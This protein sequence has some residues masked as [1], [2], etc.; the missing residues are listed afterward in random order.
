MLSERYIFPG[1]GPVPQNGRGLAV[2]PSAPAG[3]PGMPTLHYDRDALTLTGSDIDEIDDLAGA[4]RDALYVSGGVGK[5]QRSTPAIDGYS[6]IKTVNNG[7]NEGCQY[8]S[9]AAHTWA[10]IIP[11]GRATIIG[12]I[13]VNQVLALFGAPD[14]L[15]FAAASGYFPRIEAVNSSGS[16]LRFYWRNASGDDSVSAEI[17]LD[18]WF[19][20]VARAD[21]TNVKLQ[22]DNGTEQSVAGGDNTAGDGRIQLFNDGGDAGTFDGNMAF[23]AVWD[24]ALSDSDVAQAKAYLKGRFPSLNV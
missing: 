23:L 10:D 21:G 4:G 6:T 12:V 5:A 24:G 18:T 16:K 7:F 22:I 2:L 19:V 20:F 14:R 17:S 11:S 13:N 15:L 1:A 8:K 9:G 3:L